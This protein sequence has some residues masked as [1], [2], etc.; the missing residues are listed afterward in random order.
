MSAPH[1]L[2]QF[3]RDRFFDWLESNGASLLETTNPYEVVR[4]RMWV[5][6]DTG[7]PSTHIVYRRG[8]DTLTYSGAS[9][10]H[11]EAFAAFSKGKAA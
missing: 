6:T 11:Y 4:Y 10:A 2:R 3:K 9:R 1:F 5:P 7:R 8:N